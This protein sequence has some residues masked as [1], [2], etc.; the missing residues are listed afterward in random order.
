MSKY[1][2]DL[3]ILGGGAAGFVGAKTANGFGK[4]VAIIEK[5]KIGG[6]C[7]WYGCIPSKA[8][9]RAAHIA[10]NVKNLKDFGLEAEPG[11]KINTD[12]VMKHV[13]SIVRKVYNS[14][15][16]ESFEKIGINIISGKPEFISDHEVKVGGNVITAKKFLVA[17]G[18]SAF[19]PPIE[20]INEVPYLTNN[21]IFDIEKLP[22]SLIVLGGGPIGVELSQAFNRLGVNTTIVEMLERILLREESELTS[23][24]TEKLKSEGMKILTGTKAVKVT[25]KNG[26]ILLAV[27][28]KDEKKDI[29]ESDSILVAVGR[30]PNI[31]GLNLE[32]AGIKFTAKGIIA[33]NMLRTSTVNIYAAGDVVGPYQFSHMAEYQAVIAIVN[34][35]LPFRRKVDYR[36]VLWCTFTEPE[37]AHAG[38]TEDEARDKFGDKIKVYRHDFSNLDRAKTDLKEQGKAKFIC[39]L[40]GNIIGAHIIGANAGEL[41]HEAQLLK[42]F[43]INFARI[44]SVIHAYPTYSDA[45][46]KAGRQVYIDRLQNNMFINLLKKFF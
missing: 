6:E 25:A 16:P 12:K 8:L 28:G 35:F 20:G 3:I 7:T 41:I 37:L 21:T 43:K 10:N 13:R 11:I 31:E 36:N 24:L 2:Y 17:T 18:S 15:L 27:I 40:K 30:R 14:H 44:Q 42:T 38:L 26:K 9:I 1:D 22:E 34:A 32:K 19:I 23:I 39:D 5:N 4:K 33:N 46:R 29:I 45:T